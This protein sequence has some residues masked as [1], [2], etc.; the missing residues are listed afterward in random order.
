MIENER[1]LPAHDGAGAATSMTAGQMLRAARE[2]NGMPLSALASAIKVTPQKLEALEADRL[3]A[4]PDATFA[5]ALAKTVCRFLKVDPAPVL[6]QLPDVRMSELEHVAQGLNQPFRDGTRR[7]ELLKADT[8]RRPV[9][10]VSALLVVAA[11]ILWALPAGM[12]PSMDDGEAAQDPVVETP[13]P[14]TGAVPSEPVPLD[15]AASGVAPAATPP[16]AVPPPAALP[17]VPPP[18][19][20]PPAP[21]PA[22]PSPASVPAAAVVP[23]AGQAAD[24]VVVRASAPSWVE[25]RDADGRTLLS[26]QLAGGEAVTLAG[27]FPMQLKVGNVGG[28]ELTVRGKPFDLRAQSRNNVA[29][30]ELQ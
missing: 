20:V 17:A 28:T 30:L 8:L 5:R 4:L 11:L 10:V 6:A 27:R 19:A 25:L 26:R 3:D 7:Q 9:V 15:P 1:T 2:Q 29:R 13:L 24:A 12:L 14:G 21:A 16:L 23:A 22:A 18:A